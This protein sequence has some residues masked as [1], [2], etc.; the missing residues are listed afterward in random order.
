M[1]NRQSIIYNQSF[2]IAATFVAVV[3]IVC[4]RLLLSFIYSDHRVNANNDDGMAIF[5][6]LSRLLLATAIGAHPQTQAEG[7]LGSI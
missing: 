2:N 1:T 5:S 4:F 3:V 6:L 7:L